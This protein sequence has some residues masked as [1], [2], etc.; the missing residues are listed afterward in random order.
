MFLL[1]LFVV[2]LAASVVRQSE[3]IST[4]WTPIIPSFCSPKVSPNV[5]MA[6][7][8]CDS[9]MDAQVFFTNLFYN[10]FHFTNF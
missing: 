4:Y 9:L 8:A 3:A 2:S 6:L 5:T 7:L 10:D 1:T